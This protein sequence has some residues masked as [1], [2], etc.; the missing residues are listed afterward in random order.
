MHIGVKVVA[1]SVDTVQ[2]TADLKAALRVGFPMYAELDR[3][4]V[5]ESTGAMIYEGEDKQY[6]HGT[7][8]LVGPDG[9]VANSLYSS[10]PIGRFTASDIIRK[11]LFEMAK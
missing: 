3:H 7:G 6:I 9:V 8:F 4:A 11:T 10:G 5:A 1:A 2:Q